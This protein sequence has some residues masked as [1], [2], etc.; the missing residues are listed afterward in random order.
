MRDA[1]L[2]MRQ[3][4]LAARCAAVNTAL[5]EKLLVSDSELAA[6]VEA[7]QALIT[8]GVDLTGAEGSASSG[9]Q[10]LANIQWVMGRGGKQVIWVDL[11]SGTHDRSSDR[12]VQWAHA[13]VPAAPGVMLSVLCRRAPWDAGHRQ[14]ELQGV[15]AFPG[16]LRT[17]PRRRVP[18]RKVWA[19][20]WTRRRH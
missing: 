3:E 1:A 5:G 18:S 10:K 8:Q 17:S 12:V 11:C 7:C 13:A 6:T 16:A 9:T 4:T 19:R 2:G 15:E 20:W 14:A